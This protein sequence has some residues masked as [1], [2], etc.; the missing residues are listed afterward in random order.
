MQSWFKGK[1]ERYWVV[2]E[3]VRPVPAPAAR[4]NIIRDVG[5]ESPDSS[6]DQLAKKQEEKLKSREELPGRLPDPQRSPKLTFGPGRKRALTGREVADQQEADEARARRQADRLQKEAQRA[7]ELIDEQAL[8]QSQFQDEIV[9]AYFDQGI[10]H[11]PEDQWVDIDDS[12]TKGESSKVSKKARLPRLQPVPIGRAQ[13]IRDTIK[14]KQR[15]QKITVLNTITLPSR[16]YR[17]FL[18]TEA[19][20]HP[21]QNHKKKSD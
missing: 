18:S 17:L 5:E 21:T 4:P 20:F 7:E 6:S 16:S 14:P 1:R 8:L 15:S 13:A 19:I 11:D 2:D 9:A 12:P 3:E 10:K